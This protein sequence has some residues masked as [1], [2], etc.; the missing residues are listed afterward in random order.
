[1]GSLGLDYPRQA[2]E[3]LA[4][5]G[6]RT[7]GLP[8]NLPQRSQWGLHGNQAASSWRTARI[9]EIRDSGGRSHSARQPR[10]A[11]RTDWRSHPD[12][13]RSVPVDSRSKLLTA[14]PGD[15]RQAVLDEV[16]AMHKAGKVRNPIGLLS[17]LARKAGLGQFAPNYS[18]RVDTPRPVA[19]RRGEVRGRRDIRLRL[20]AIARACLMRRRHAKM[21]APEC[22]RR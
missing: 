14:C 7:A 6:I 8:L 5:T 12:C 13:L 1:M 18:M 17:V 21:R 15:L 20:P 16:D 10:N 3:T 22:Y 4:I 2:P 19:E 11:L 9:P